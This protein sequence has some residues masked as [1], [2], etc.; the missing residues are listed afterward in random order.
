MEASDPELTELGV[1]DSAGVVGVSEVRST[2]SSVRR[3][4]SYPFENVLRMVGEIAD[5]VS[6]RR[7]DPFPKVRF[8]VVLMERTGRIGL[9]GCC[10]RGV[11]TVNK[12]TIVGAE[13]CS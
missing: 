4:G 9:L 5:N 8:C 6:N 7:L 3:V 11:G 10:S 13:V 1:P 2:A 12:G